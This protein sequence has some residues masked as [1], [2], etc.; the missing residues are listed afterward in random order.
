ML[1]KHKYLLLLPFA[2]FLMVGCSTVPLE[3]KEMSENAKAFNTPPE[4][5]AGLYVYR[6]SFVGQALKKDIWVDN[7]CLGE[8]A[9]GIFFYQSV[10]G[11][12]PHTIATESEFS[13]N[14]LVVD[15]KAG[16]NYFV[17]QYIKMGVFG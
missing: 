8:T 11:N 15:T 14:K 4:G 3:P 16:K 6:D 17:R 5:K 7:K 12:M 10:K 9:N 2:L 13:P 1:S